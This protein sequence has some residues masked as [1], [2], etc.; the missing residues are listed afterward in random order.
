MAADDVGTPATRSVTP[1]DP[2]QTAPDWIDEA[3]GVALLGGLAVAAFAPIG[4]SGKTIGGCPSGAGAGWSLVTVES[5]GIDPEVAV[6][7]A[8]L[9]GNGDGYT[10]LKGLVFRDNTVQHNS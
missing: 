2:G 4:A 9:N 8:S 7:I 10:C 5:L 6:G 3:D 1:A